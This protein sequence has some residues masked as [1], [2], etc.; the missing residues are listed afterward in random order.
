MDGGTGRIIQLKRLGILDNFFCENKIFYSDPISRC[1]FYVFHEKPDDSREC[2]F[3]AFIFARHFTFVFRFLVIP[4]VVEPVAPVRA[5]V[6][7]EKLLLW[8]EGLHVDNNH[9]LVGHELYIAIVASK[10]LFL[11]F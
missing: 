4:Q 5:I 11:R 9:L 8:M 2:C 6:A 1:R 3:Q 10:I 7:V